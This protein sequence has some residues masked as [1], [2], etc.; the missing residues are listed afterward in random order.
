MKILVLGSDGYIGYPLTQ[1]LLK[2]GHQVIGLDN[3]SRRGRVSYLGSNSL[4]PIKEPDIRTKYLNT[5]GEYLGTIQH[6]LNEHSIDGLKNAIRKFS[7][8]NN[9]IDAIV[10]LAE[11]PSAPWSMFNAQQAVITQRENVLG[12]LNLLWIMKEICPEAHLVKLGTM[13]EYGTPECDIPEGVVPEDCIGNI[14]DEDHGSVAE[15]PMS[16]LLFPR[17][18]GS[19]YHLTKV[20]DTYNIHFACRNWGLRSTDIMQGVLFGLESGTRF[21][22]DEYFGTAINRFCVQAIIGMPLTIYGLGQQ[23]R[24]FLPLKDSIQCLIIALENPPELGEYRTLNQFE[25]IY[26]INELANMVCRGAKQLGIHASISHIP[27]PRKEAEEH[28]YNPDHQKLFDLG[29]IPTTNI[30]GEINNLLETILPYKDQVI[31]DVIMPKT[32]WRLT[33]G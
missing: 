29:Y 12:T 11:Q 14:Q 32:N 20:H 24:G 6:T 27:N 18:P 28:Y 21:D 5:L 10:H 22:Y 7:P 3:Y 26:S 17:T 1:H 4:T 9:S 2:E 25:N 30:Q 16:N 15:C 13:G 31:K 8:S 23:T 19:F 33:N